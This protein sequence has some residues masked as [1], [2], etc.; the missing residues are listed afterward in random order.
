MPSP[1]AFLTLPYVEETP[2]KRRAQ[3]RALPDHD[4]HISLRHFRS[5]PS[6]ARKEETVTE[7]GGQR[8]ARGSC[9]KKS[10][11][12]LLSPREISILSL[13][14]AVSCCIIEN[15]AFFPRVSFEN[16]TGG[17][18]YDRVPTRKAEQA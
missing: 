6:Y 3:L 2:Q 13:Q 8:A 5:V 17:A 1:R 16:E 4:F 10:K 15:E 11:N 7:T 12:P 18:L 9:E 14:I